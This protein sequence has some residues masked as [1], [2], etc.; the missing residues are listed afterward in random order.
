V[1]YKSRS[2]RVKYFQRCFIKIISCAGTEKVTQTKQ[3]KHAGETNEGKRRKAARGKVKD[4]V[5]VC[6]SF[7]C[8]CLEC[9]Q[10]A[11]A[12]LSTLFPFLFHSDT[13]Q[14]LP[15]V[16]RLLQLC[17]P[18]LSLLFSMLSAIFH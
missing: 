3:E 8:L 6:G 7:L 9:K 14:M 4:A 16:C 10:A 18:R 13:H 12:R 11:T 15:S 5:N 1:R 2:R 17:R